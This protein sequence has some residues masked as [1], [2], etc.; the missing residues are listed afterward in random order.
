MQRYISVTLH[1]SPKNPILEEKLKNITSTK[2]QIL[3]QIFF[4]EFL[5]YGLWKYIQSTV[6]PKPEELKFGENVHPTLCVMCHVSHVMCHVS[7][8]TCHVSRVTCQTFFF[9]FFYK[10]K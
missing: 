1:V 10:K 8:V 6:N 5:E 7:R 3:P 2:T 4:S 9:T